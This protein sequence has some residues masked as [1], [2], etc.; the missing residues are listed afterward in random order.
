VQTLQRRYADLRRSGSIPSTARPSTRSATRSSRSLCP[1]KCC[2]GNKYARCWLHCSFRRHPP[3]T[4]SC[5]YMSVGARAREPLR[6]AAIR[7]AGSD[8]GGAL[9]DDGES[10]AISALE[11]NGFPV[12]IS[13]SLIPSLDGL[14]FSALPED[15]SL[16]RARVASTEPQFQNP[17]PR[18]SLP[19]APR[20]RRGSS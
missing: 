13:E 20:A 5:G 4:R 3:P 18:H 15:R 2:A 17:G 19:K 7:I 9:Q 8:E 16:L 10:S 14:S 6:R 12:A 11:R 1:A